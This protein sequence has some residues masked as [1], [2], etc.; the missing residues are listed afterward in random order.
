MSAHALIVSAHALIA[1]EDRLRFSAAVLIIHTPLS[2]VAY[3]P[4]V[5]SGDTSCVIAD[6][7]RR[8]NPW[9]SDAQTSDAGSVAQHPPLHPKSSFFCCHVVTL[10][11]F[12]YNNL[13]TYILRV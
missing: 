12:E 4:T 2:N 10:S 6:D 11:H 3:S 8:A 13:I 7:T 1:F 5:L 9:G